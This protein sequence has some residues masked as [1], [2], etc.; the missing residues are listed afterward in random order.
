MRHPLTA[1]LDFFS[2]LFSL[3][4]ERV[5][6]F[7]ADVS[8]A[9]WWYVL[10]YRRRIIL[11][12]IA[13]AF[14]DLTPREQ[15]ALGRR[16]TTHLVRTLLEF[17]RIPRLIA[18]E[19]VRFEGI[20]HLITAKQ[21]GKGVL[22]LAG[23][24]GSFELAIAAVVKRVAPVA[25]VVKPFPKPVDAFI[26]GIRRSAGLEVIFAEGAIKPILRALKNNSLVAFALD[27][28]ATRSIGVFVDF[29]G[30]RAS[31]LSALAVLAARTRAPVVAATPYRDADGT[32]VL[33]VSA[34]I[35][36]QEGATHEETIAHM[37]QV[38]TR[39]IEDAIRAHPEQWFWTHKRWRTQPVN[40]PATEEQ[41]A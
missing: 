7:L 3:L 31:T 34:P 16:A 12:N 5:I 36:F 6:A 33:K 23:H 20:E 14:P 29:F 27:Q 30:K 35:P 28:N 32:N 26:N 13:R 22:C 2:A 25:M 24:L 9:F 4:P 17:F 19:R 37:T 18:E 11:E 21:E 40:I 10:R 1:L 38:Y 8:G 39:A 15:R 41:D